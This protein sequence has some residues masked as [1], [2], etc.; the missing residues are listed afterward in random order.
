MRNPLK[1]L[2][3]PGS[4]RASSFNRGLLVAARNIDPSEIEIEIYEGLG[5]LPIFSQDLEGENMPARASELD[6]ALR[7]ADAVLIATPE[8]TGSIPG[9]LKNLLDWAARPFGNGAFQGKPTAIIGASPGQY[10][11]ARSVEMTKNILGALGATPADILMATFGGPTVVL[12]PG[13]ALGLL[14][15][16][17]MTALSIP[18]PTGV[19]VLALASIG[20]IRRRREQA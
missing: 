2:A 17:N 9:G 8:Y 3:V 20:L 5:E 1:I 13:V 18:G 6:R 7:N 12:I 10:G 4:V 16:D 15:S 14:P 19:G 11:A